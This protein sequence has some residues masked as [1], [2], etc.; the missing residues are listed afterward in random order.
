MD[1]CNPNERKN[2]NRIL[3]NILAGRTVSIPSTVENP[4][5]SQIPIDRE[6]GLPV[7]NIPENVSFQNDVTNINTNITNIENNNVNNIDNDQVFVVP[8]TDDS[9]INSIEFTPEQQSEFEQLASN[10]VVPRLISRISTSFPQL[11]NRVFGII[12]LQ[13]AIEQ[14]VPSEMSLYVTHLEDR[15]IENDQDKNNIYQLEHRFA[16]HAALPLTMS[17]IRSQFA[18]D[19]L[20]ALR[21]VLISILWGFEVAPGFARMTYE[22]GEFI[23]I[24]GS[25]AYYR[26]DF[27]SVETIRKSSYRNVNYY[28][29]TLNKLC[30]CPTPTGAGISGQIDLKI[31]NEFGT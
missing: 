21:D 30:P 25:V 12:D 5:N 29:W 24:T 27:S 9:T 3:D 19:Q 18:L 20:Y 15:K 17:D 8:G 10:S 11:E 28:E 14:G 23:N 2:P 16:L 22:G 31:N 13:H 1:E 4:D 7:N 26:Y 6:T